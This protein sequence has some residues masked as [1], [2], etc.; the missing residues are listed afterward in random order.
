MPNQ[1]VGTTEI[2]VI[3]GKRYTF[4]HLKRGTWLI[5]PLEE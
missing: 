4:N 3:D 2:V 5:A 1:P